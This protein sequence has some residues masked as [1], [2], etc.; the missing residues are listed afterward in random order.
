V[1]TWDS[2]PPSRN[3]TRRRNEDAKLRND[4]GNVMVASFRVKNKTPEG[5]TPRLF[6]GVGRLLGF[7]RSCY[8]PAAPSP[9][10]GT[11]PCFRS[12][13]GIQLKCRVDYARLKT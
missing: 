10:P 6:R 1:G 3:S 13:G 12:M 5:L 11:D 7:A 2:L 9:V 4:A 8:G